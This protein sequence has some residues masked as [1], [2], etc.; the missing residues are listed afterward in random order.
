MHKAEVEPIILRI[1]KRFHWK[2]IND[3]QVNQKFAEMMNDVYRQ[4]LI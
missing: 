3:H 2:G 4:L 1:V